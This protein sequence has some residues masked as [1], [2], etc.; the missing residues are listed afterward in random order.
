MALALPG[1][2][3]IFSQMQEAL[4]HVKSKRVTLPPGVHDALDD[5]KWLAEDVAKR[6]TRMYELVPL[7]PTVDGYHD[8]SG[9]MCAGVVIPG[10]TATPRTFPPQPSAA[11]PS[12]NPTGAHPIF[13]RMTSP[14]DI[15][16]SL[17][18]W[19]NPQGTVNNSELELSGGV[20]Y[21][22]C[23]AQ[24]FVVKGR[25]TLARIDNTVGLWWQRK[26]SATCT[27]P[28]THLLRLQVMNQRFHRYVPRVYFVSGVDN[29]I[30]DRPS[31]SEDLTENQLLTY[32]KTHFPQPLP[33]QLWT[34]SHK[35]ASGI[36]S[37]LRRKTSAR[38][39][40][41][42]EPLPSMAT[43]PSGPTSAQGWPSTPYSSL[44]NTLS[45]S[46]TPS[47]G[48]TKLETSRPAA[49]RTVNWTGD[50]DA[51]VQGPKDDAHRK[52]GRATTATVP[53]LL[54]ARPPAILG[55]ANTSPSPPPARLHIGSFQ[56]SLTASY[57]GH[58]HYR[59]H[60]ALPICSQLLS[61][62]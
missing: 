34:L 59:L 19:K 30:S 6:P 48:T 49:C 38:D 31:R 3:G 28:P 39:C 55:K 41:L 27:S 20:V 60:D 15:V 47:P 12:P 24:C 35:L 46:S 53:L 18:S 10:P 61:R 45:P 52:T 17:V 16:E 36:A 43:G 62:R 44:I 2:P 32:L 22:D 4:C 42:A 54:R 33:W 29:L 50:R 5:F 37:A 51:G 11:R 1:A 8:A 57:F 9:Y 26:S 7:R 13:W 56:G 40:L 21:S 25:T 58:D 14:K 23:V